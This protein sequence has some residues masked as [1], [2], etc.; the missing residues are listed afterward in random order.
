M[1]MIIISII[2]ISAAMIFYSFIKKRNLITQIQNKQTSFTYNGILELNKNMPNYYGS[3][4][5]LLNELEGKLIKQ[6]NTGQTELNTISNARKMMR[7]GFVNEEMFSR[8]KLLH[9]LYA[10]DFRDDKN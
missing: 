10:N 4:G 7:K 3:T 2:S 1:D 5:I 6:K 8:I 9:S